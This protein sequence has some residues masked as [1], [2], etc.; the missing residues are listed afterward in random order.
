MPA[1][2]ADIDTDNDPSNDLYEIWYSTLPNPVWS[3]S[4]DWALG[5]TINAN[6]PT[7]LDDLT[8][9]GGG[10]ITGIKF[11]FP[12]EL[13]VSFEQTSNFKLTYRLN[14]FDGANGQIIRNTANVYYTF[15]SINKSYSSSADVKVWGPRPLIR[16]E[17]S[18]TST[19][20]YKHGDEVRFRILVENSAEYSSAV[21]NDPIIID[22]L[23]KELEFDSTDITSWSL[24]NFQGLNLPEL[25]LDEVIPDFV[26]TDKNTLIRWKFNGSYALP[27]GKAFA[28][29]L[30]AKIKMYTTPP[31]TY[32]NEAQITS[33]T[34]PYFN[35]YYFNGFTIDTDNRSGDSDNTGNLITRKAS[36]TVNE[37]VKLSS[38]KQVRGELDDPLIMDGWRKG[39]QA[40]LARTTEGGRVDYKLT[41]TN[42][43]NI[44]VKDIVIVDVLPNQG[45]TGV[46]DSAS[47]GSD[48]STVLTDAVP[49]IPNVSIEYSISNNVKM[50]TGVWSSTPPADITSV[51]AL[52]FT[53]H[54]AQNL[55]PGMSTSIIWSMK[56][57]VGTPTTKIAWNSFGYKAKQANNGA[58]ILAAEPPK[59]GVNI[60]P[61]PAG[62]PSL[63]NYVWVDLNENGIQDEGPEW[64]LNGVRVE[65]LDADDNDKPVEKFGQNVFTITGDDKDGNPGYYLFPALTPNHNYKVRFHM[66]ANLPSGYDAYPFTSW[67]EKNKLG[68]TTANDSDVG[69]A[70]AIVITQSIP[71]TTTQDLNWDAGL[72]PP[73]GAI[74]DYVWHDVNGDGMQDEA[75]TSGINGVVVELLQETSPGIWTSKGTQTTADKGGNTSLPGYYEFTGLL[76]GKYRVKFPEKAATDRI[77]TFKGRGSNS[78]TDS[79]ANSNGLTDDIVLRLGEIIH[80]I[81]A[82]YVEPVTIGDYVWE[83]IDGDGTQNAGDSPRAGILVELLNT[84]D[85]P[86]KKPDGTNRTM[87]TLADGKYLF[88]DLLPGTYKVRFSNLPA[89]YGF[90]KKGVGSAALDSNVIRTANLSSG[91]QTSGITNDITTVTDPGASD[92]TIDAGIVKLV[93]LGDYVWMDA[94]QNGIQDAVESGVSG[95]IVNLYYDDESTTTNYRTATTSS[96]GLY[97][98]NNLYPGKYTVEFE[99]ADGYLFTM[100][101]VGADATVNSKVNVPAV[102]V[103]KAKTDQVT[104]L[105]N[106]NLNLDAGLVELASVGDKIW[107]DANDNGKQD[108]EELPVSGVKVKLLDH[109]GNPVLTNAYGTAITEITSGADGLYKFDKLLPG[110]YQVKFTLPTG[111]WFTQSKVGTADK[112]SDAFPDAADSKIGIA[113]VTLKAGENNIDIDA[114]VLTL[115]ALGDKVWHDINGDGIQDASD[116]GVGG[117]KVQLLNASDDSP[118]LTDAYGT[119]ISI[120]TTAADGLYK[121]ENLLPGTYKVKFTNLPAGYEFTLKNVTSGTDATDSD[122][123]PSTGLTDAITLNRAQNMNVDAGIVTRTQIG[124]RVWYDKNGDGI[125]D[126]D[127]TLEPGIAGIT[128]ELYKTSNLITPIASTQTDA[129]GIYHFKN[130]WPDDYKVKFILP[131]DYYILSPKNSTG[132]TTVN[133][134]DADSATGWSD[135]IT[136]DSGDDID[137]IDAGIIEL[138]SIGDQLWDDRNNDGIKDSTE[139]GYSGGIVHLLQSDGI[140][141]VLVGG[142]P[143]T[144]T[145][146]T[147]GYYLFEKLLPGTYKVRFELPAGYMFSKQYASG[148]SLPLKDSNVN[149]INGITDSIILTP[150]VHDMSIDA[151]IVKL[152]ELGDRVW[153]DRVVNG[154]QDIGENSV[155]GVTVRL[156]DAN[157]API[158]VG[159]VDVTTTTDADGKYLF[160]LLVPGTYK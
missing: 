117:V 145:T 92:L 111:Y 132:S 78:A 33:N 156:L 30:K 29:N 40:N 22:M 151:G 16:L 34:E 14:S 74:G 139:S 109:L 46:I 93:S 106:D 123:N 127:H 116:P 107:L 126:V 44:P 65:L 63:G 136:V 53:L 50:E 18:I 66:P 108:P 153:M 42:E 38:V 15:N 67:T 75:A 6:N 99:R 2:F 77:L 159:G 128:V 142:V 60:V 155:S 37:T 118:V 10:N 73:K 146:D 57:P 58:D 61:I 125:Q 49:P 90:T 149:P 140:T 8:T 91:V 112:D 31:G 3:N 79:N 27:I 62:T 114:G 134:S 124:D 28:I 26:N 7:L 85:T 55:E 102:T 21:F 157:G 56:A 25:E 131:S 89:G 150:G 84:S 97:K 130:L 104:L 47:R 133:D 70:S 4:S 80:T 158:K 98:F 19:G 101:G 87:T 13:P 39:D 144:V 138:A 105:N 69:G 64:G 59:V 135:I 86:I 48:W 110:S 5:A 143:A 71:L 83:D 51:T 1:S 82:G 96:T 152:A 43:S 113:A 160:Q 35:D 9:W 141:P 68:S 12:N 24:D 41:V 103:T 17:K 72:V 100:K 45:D 95:V 20:P 54:T 120:I 137:S 23:P 81:D 147:N 36:F 52:R 76:P 88:A 32:D 119:A 122:V 148:G 11:V 121:F 154:I 129:N 94:N 115:A